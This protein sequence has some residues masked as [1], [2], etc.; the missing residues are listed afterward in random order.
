MRIYFIVFSFLFSL[1]MQAQDSNSFWQKSHIGVDYLYGNIIAHK[2]V[3]QSIIKG[4]PE[5]ILLNWSLHSNLETQWSS[6]YNLPD[7][8]ISLFY[9]NLKNEA[10]GENYSLLVHYNFYFL[11]RTST[12]QLVLKLASGLGI[13]TNP[14]HKANNPKNIAIGSNI[15]SSTFLNIYY[16]ANDILPKWDIKMGLFLSHISNG[17]YK[18][19]N[20]GINTWGFSVGLNYS[21]NQDRIHPI[22]KKTTEQTNTT[23]TGL[24]AILRLGVAES[25]II[26]S[27]QFVNYTLSAYGY[28]QFNRVSTIQL[29]T[30]YFISK[31]FRELIRYERSYTQNEQYGD[32]DDY[33]R[34][35]IFLGHEL[36][37]SAISVITHIGYYLYKPVDIHPVV[38]QRMGIKRYF[39][40][41]FFM[42]ITVKSHNFSRAEMITLG[43]GF[44]L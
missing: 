2:P 4:H 18:S 30:D 28:H 38:Y 20:L 37:I 6:D 24:G 44:Q 42:S 34:L 33:H 32:L 16:L 22:S 39:S 40:N 15:N 36:S 13:N 14:F 31:A 25:G 27:G 3:I 41:D 29:G 11:D 21:F 9:Q 35:G 12:H 17:K 7:Y 19:P 1:Q 8:G 26:G 5:G 43:L 23:T 10:L